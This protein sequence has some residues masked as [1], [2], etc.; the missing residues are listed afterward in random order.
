[1]VANCALLDGDTRQ[2]VAIFIGL[3]SVAYEL[4]STKDG[5]GEITPLLRGVS[6]LQHAMV[7]TSIVGMSCMLADGAHSSSR[8]WDTMSGQQTLVTSLP[9]D[10]WSSV[11]AK[12]NAPVLTILSNVCSTMQ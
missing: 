11:C 7:G 2:I 4:A 8:L 9:P 3:T 10:R 6:H 12:E 1:M 5:D